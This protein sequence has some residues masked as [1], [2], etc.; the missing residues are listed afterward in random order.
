M[1]RQ[2]GRTPD[3]L[4][5]I[6]ITLDFTE[7][8]DASVL[9]KTGNTIVWCS[10]SVAN[11]QPRWLKMEGPDNKGW[12]TA[13]YNMLPSSTNPRGRR[14]GRRGPVGGRTHEIQ[15]LI[16]RSLRAVV[17]L[18]KLGPRTFNIDCDVLQADG[19]T[20]TAA[21][22]GAFVALALA[23]DRYI[24]SGEMNASPFLD[25]LAATSCGVVNGQPVLDLPYPEDVAAA[26]DMNVVM[27]G[28]GKY[29]EVQGTGEEAVFT[30]E[31]LQQLLALAQ[32][33]CAA[34]TKIQAEAL[35]G[36]KNLGDLFVT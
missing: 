23:V 21:I 13:E 29:V 3:E 12:V 2:D 35:S 28:S 18:E 6:E 1:A 20:R 8:P 17:D 36:C 5:P 33:G 4:R 11:E 32:T 24:D 19:G 14:E 9:I 26:V 30:G 27:T 22:T 16:G 34:L 31:E 25:S 7:N 10:V 15:R